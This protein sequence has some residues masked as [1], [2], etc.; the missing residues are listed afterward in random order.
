[1]TLL[2]PARGH[3]HKSAGQSPCQFADVVQSMS[4]HT[5]LCWLTLHCGVVIF[6]FVQALC[7]SPQP[8][9]PQAELMQQAK[10]IQLSLLTHSA[11]YHMHGS[12]QSKFVPVSI[13]SA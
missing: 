6:R 1:M 11:L 9:Q 13:C 8:H 2:S 10:V 5:L 4:M 12:F 7:S 3:C